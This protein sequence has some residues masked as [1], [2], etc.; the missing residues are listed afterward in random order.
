MV[1]IKFVKNWQTKCIKFLDIND[2]KLNLK[3]YIRYRNV[4]L[5][6]KIRT[7]K[8]KKIMTPKETQPTINVFKYLIITLPII[9]KKT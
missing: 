9:Y 8:Q 3:V 6:K 5:N 1:F 2:I 7:S 4:I